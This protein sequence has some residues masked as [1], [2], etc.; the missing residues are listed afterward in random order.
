M[1]TR[2]AFE[3]T[4]MV[5][6]AIGGST[7]VIHL[8]AIARR[9][10]VE[11]NLKDFDALCRNIPLLANIQPSGMYFMEDL[12]LCRRLACHNEKLDTQLHGDCITVNGR[13]VK[14][15]YCDGQNATTA[16]LLQLPGTLLT[17]QQAL[18]YCMAIFA[19]MAR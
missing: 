7:F 12:F 1:L 19:K 6:A 13:T 17:M 11:L 3:N 14:R 9:I 16:M 10:G 15:K 8:I 2:K 5:N 4:I 18:P